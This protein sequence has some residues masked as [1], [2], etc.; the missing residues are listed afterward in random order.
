MWR[1]APRQVAAFYAD[2]SR[3]ATIGILSTASARAV[4]ARTIDGKQV[5]RYEVAS[6]WFGALGFETPSALL[7]ETHAGRKAATVRCTATACE[8]ASKLRP[9]ETLRTS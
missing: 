7:L 8:R 3:I 1:R 9:A 5:G 2:G 6:G 4:E